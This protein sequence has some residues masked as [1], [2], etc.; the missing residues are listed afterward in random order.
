MTNY[1]RRTKCITI[2]YI[3][4]QF[5]SIYPP[6]Y[7]SPAVHSCHVLMTAKMTIG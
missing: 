6:I 2:V 5:A 3:T 7:Q 1:E 4:W